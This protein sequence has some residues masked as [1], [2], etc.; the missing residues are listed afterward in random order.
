MLNPK[1]ANI[2][3]EQRLPA[4]D[5]GEDGDADAS[6]TNKGKTHKHTD[7]KILTPRS[8][9]LSDTNIAYVTG[10]DAETKVQ[11]IPMKVIEHFEAALASC[12][13]KYLSKMSTGDCGYTHTHYEP[14]N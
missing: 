3:K 13:H 14:D 11:W 9:T 10:T 8:K 5:L 6:R 1:R 2:K 4:D 7:V 12:I